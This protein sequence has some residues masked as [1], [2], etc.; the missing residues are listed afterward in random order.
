MLAE[1]GGMFADLGRADQHLE[2]AAEPAALAGDDLVVNPLLGR[3]HLG[4]RYVAIA[5]HLSLP[6]WIWRRSIAKPSRARHAQGP[7][8][9][10][11][12]INPPDSGLSPCRAIFPAKR[13]A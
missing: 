9:R 5:A 8:V 1:L 4:H 11:R 6:L 10:L 7:R 13:S 2:R 3:V 12:R